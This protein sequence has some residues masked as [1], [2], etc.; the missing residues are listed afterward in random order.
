MKTIIFF[1]LNLFVFLPFLQAQDKTAQPLVISAFNNATLLPGQ[2]VLG[3]WGT[4]LHPGLSLGTEF[5]LKAQE[6]SLFL[7]TLKLGY[8]YHQYVQHGI[9]LY[10]ETGYR[11]YLNT[12]DLEARLGAGYLHSIAAT[13]VFE[14]DDAGRYNQLHTL[15]RPQFMASLA[16][17]AGYTINT[18]YRIF[19]NYQFYL[20]MPFVRE[21]V[22]LVP[23]SAVHLGIMLP[24]K[25]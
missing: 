22:P 5:P 9:Q 24:V 7:Q 21:Y 16:L 8:F 13:T 6:K 17:G 14:L 3:I 20:Q 15:G 4:P 25:I 1:L 18:D 11:K 2:G 10:T 12:W 23:N 19:L